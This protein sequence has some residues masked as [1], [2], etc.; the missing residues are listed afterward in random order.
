MSNA[1]NIPQSAILDIDT[2]QFG[3]WAP[4]VTPASPKFARFRNA[5]FIPWGAE[6]GQEN[7]YPR[8]I[9]ELYISNSLLR[10]VTDYRAQ[11]VAG[12]GLVIQGDRATACEKYFAKIGVNKAM[13]GELAMQLALFNG[14]AM[15]V[16]WQRS[17][18]RPA[19][20][21]NQR[22]SRV[23]I[24]RPDEAGAI[25]KYYISKDW[26]VVTTTGRLRR[27]SKAQEQYRPV[28]IGAF[29]G[30]KAAARNN[31]GRELLY[32]TR[33]NPA[34]DF[35]PLPDAET[36]YEELTV[37]DDVIAYQKSYIANGMTSSAVVYLPFSPTAP[38]G[39]NWSDN[40]RRR[41]KEIKEGI[42]KDLTGKSK[43]GQVTFITYDPQIVKSSEQLP[44][45]EKPVE[46][47]NDKKF[48]EIQKEARQNAM[49]GLGVVSPDLMGI[50]TA[51]G[52]AS[53]AEELLTADELSFNIDA[54]PLQD[55]L[56]NALYQLAEAAGFTG[57][58]LSIPR[59]QP[60]S[61]QLTPDMVAAGIITADEYRE[62]ALGLP[63][64]QQA[65]DPESE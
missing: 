63:P 50:R 58:E 40:D 37:G 11:Q 9:E 64:L 23:R 14:M 45:F 60:I 3:A 17:Y 27:A 8:K 46:E 35:Y 52:F 24:G 36:V 15:Q 33:A 54:A 19:R 34:T 57:V 39:E 32:L 42:V 65:P 55:V 6:P 1:P 30:E 44:R 61:R 29:T 22:I 2:K 53:Q 48:L 4:E 56:L 25:T 51:S 16:L 7:L 59:R 28:E 18:E 20:V 26:S 12:A 62:M 31:Q 43:A 10:R 5:P 49:T 41:H 47:R 21:V 38:V 13:I